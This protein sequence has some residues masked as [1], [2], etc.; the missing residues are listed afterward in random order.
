M[1][2]NPSPVPTAEPPLHL[3]W[4]GHDAAVYACTHWHYSES[5]PAGKL[6][7]VGVW[8]HGEFIGVILYSRGAAIHIGTPFGLKQTEICELTRVALRRHKTPVSRM[9]AISFK[10]L[11][12]F[13]PGIRLVISFADSGEGHHGGIYQ[14]GGWLYLGESLG[15]HK[16]R[17]NGVLVHPKTL[18][19]TYGIGG[20]SIPWLRKNVDPKAERVHMPGKYKY[21]M[22]LDPAMMKKLIPQ[23]QPY[24]KRTRAGSTDTGTVALQATGD[25]ANPI[26]ALHFPPKDAP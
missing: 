15:T 22:P 13:C 26:P 3:E 6:V 23:V 21:A 17:V 2:K 4:V 9:L 5:V 19:S 14:A 11:R 25:G 24:P 12:Q 8:E 1:R 10:M 18:H 7:K 20:Q 16:Y